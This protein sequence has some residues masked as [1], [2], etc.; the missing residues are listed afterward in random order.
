MSDVTPLIEERNWIHNKFAEVTIQ[1]TWKSNVRRHLAHRSRHRIVQVSV[2]R[3][4]QFQSP[5]ANVRQGLVVQQLAFVSVRHKSKCLTLINLL[6][7]RAITDKCCTCRK[8]RNRYTLLYFPEKQPSSSTL[9]RDVQTPVL[10]L[11]GV[12]SKKKK[13]KMNSCESIQ[14]SAQQPPLWTCDLARVRNQGQQPLS[15]KCD[16]GPMFANIEN[17]RVG[18][19]EEMNVDMLR[20]FLR[21]VTHATETMAPILF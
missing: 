7:G 11:F 21:S 3:R 5:E 1:L 17:T 14:I 15:W 2:G 4:R 9:E 6:R 8:T 12:H 18:T 16:S 13:H 10:M 19:R 20:S